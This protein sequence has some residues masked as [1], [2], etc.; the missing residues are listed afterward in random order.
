[1]VFG[2]HARA[3]CLSVFFYRRL[4]VEYRYQISNF[5]IDFKISNITAFSCGRGYF[6]QPSLCGRRSF[7]IRI[8]KDAFSKRS[9]YVWKWLE[10]TEKDK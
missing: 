7:S 8:K 10:P 3:F 6:R 5:I 2:D 9:G 4:C 1:M